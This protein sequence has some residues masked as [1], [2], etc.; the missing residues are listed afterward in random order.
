MVFTHFIINKNN[1][2]PLSKD[3]NGNDFYKPYESLDL[4]ESIKS[5]LD[6]NIIKPYC[7][8]KTKLFTYNSYVYAIV[9]IINNDIN[10]INDLVDF[11]EL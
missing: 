1:A 7:I 10:T 9:T 4:L 5:D 3:K 8:Y 11:N 6:I 2:S